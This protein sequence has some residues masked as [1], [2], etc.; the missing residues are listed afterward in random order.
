MTMFV[1]TKHQRFSTEDRNRH[2][3][4]TRGHSRNVNMINSFLKK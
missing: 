4:W 3:S 1:I 2:K